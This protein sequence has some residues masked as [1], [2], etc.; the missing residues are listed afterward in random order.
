MWPIWGFRSKIVLDGVITVVDGK[1]ILRQ[2]AQKKPAGAVNEAVQQIAFADRVLLNKV[3]LL[4]PD[5][6]AAVR[7]PPPNNNNF[8]RPS[9]T[10]LCS[11]P[12]PPPPCDAL[13]L[14]GGTLVGR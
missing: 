13:C 7:T 14:R 10:S 5:E 6:I 4:T 9:S 11:M 3:D 8:I 12:P 1:N 2:L